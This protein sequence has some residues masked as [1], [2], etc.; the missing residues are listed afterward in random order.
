MVVITATERPTLHV[1]SKYKKLSIKPFQRK[2]S[3]CV[4]APPPT[5][6]V[7]SVIV[8]LVLS[9]ASIPS[10][11]DVDE[12]ASIDLFTKRLFPDLLSLEGLVTIRAFFCFFIFYVS[13]TTMMFTD[14]WS[15]KTS[16][17]PDSKLLQ[18]SIP[19][20]GLRTQF[21]YTSVTWNILGLSMG[22]SSHI[23]YLALQ[24][25][26]VS[27]WLLRCGLLCWEMAA[28]NTLLV[29]AVVRYAIWP[30]CIKR[31]DSSNCQSWRALTW[32]NANAFMSICE[33]SLLGGL[34]VLF[35][36]ISLSVILGTSYIIFSWCHMHSWTPDGRPNFLYFFL[37]TTRGWKTTYSLYSLLATLMGFFS[38]FAGAGALLKHGGNGQ[39]SLHIGFALFIL[40]VVCRFRD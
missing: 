38:V 36:H 37:D 6:A 31:G 11:K 39:I 9:F 22:L 1:K 16:Y 7:A 3:S 27:P 32:H 2:D 33:V 4:K 40:S 34:P 25:Q 23:G 18:A 19:I 13:F 21:P 8:F 20:R 14:G 26:E 28:P 15:T 12:V 5:H 29:S 17:M 10:A 35:S 30:A 24:N